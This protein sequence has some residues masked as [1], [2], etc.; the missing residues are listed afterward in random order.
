MK[1]V[2]AMS[3]SRES[4]FCPPAVDSE[5]AGETDEFFAPPLPEPPPPA[6]RVGRLGRPREPARS[7]TF[8]AWCVAEDLPGTSSSSSLVFDCS[9]I[10][11]VVGLARLSWRFEEPSATG[12]PPAMPGEL[13]RDRHTLGAAV[14]GWIIYSVQECWRLSEEVVLPADWD[15]PSMVTCLRLSALCKHVLL[16]HF[17][18]VT[19][20]MFED[21]SDDVFCRVLTRPREYLGT[22]MRGTL[23]VELRRVTVGA[24]IPWDTLVVNFPERKSVQYWRR[25]SGINRRARAEAPHAIA[26]EPAADESHL[27]ELPEAKRAR[28][29][30]S[31]LAQPPPLAQTTWQKDPIK[32]VDAVSFSLK[33]RQVAEFSDALDDAHRYNYEGLDEP[34]PRDNK[35]NDPSRRTIDRAKGKVDCVG[36]LLERRLFAQEM[37]EDSILAVN[38]F[39]DSSP[40]VGSELQ[41]M[42]VAALRAL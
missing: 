26:P 34:P 38:C 7:G 30:D 32:L 42:L 39:A 40:V 22:L 15:L 13:G 12:E 37:A 29:A 1:R 27:L 28:P 21:C 11:S 25:K 6:R 20:D 4:F 14:A 9:G 8:G 18:A 17:E 2:L 36:M 10:R 33:L 35:M 3:S 23:P 5:G 31:E 41:G 16:E 19:M 24:R